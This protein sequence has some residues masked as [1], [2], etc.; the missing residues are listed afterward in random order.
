[1]MFKTLQCINNINYSTLAQL[2]IQIVYDV[3]IK[4]QKVLFVLR[5]SVI[6][7]FFLCTKLNTIPGLY[8]T[9]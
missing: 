1:M 3:D 8:V 6:L 9:S 5:N 7:L 4:T 2:N